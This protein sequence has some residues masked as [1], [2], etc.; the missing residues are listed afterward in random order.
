ME[1]SKLP[2]LY[3]TQVLGHLFPI[4]IAA[5]VSAFGVVAKFVFYKEASALKIALLVSLLMCLGLLVS[6]YY[7]WKELYIKSKFANSL[8]I[9]PGF[10]LPPRGNIGPPS[11]GLATLTCLMLSVENKG[12]TKIR[13]L[14]A[15]S[16][17]GAGVWLSSFTDSDFSTQ[18]GA[19]TELA[20]GQ[21][22]YI[23]IA[24]ADTSKNT[25]IELLDTAPSELRNVASA[26]IKLTEDVEREAYIKPNAERYL[27]FSRGSLGIRFLAEDGL[28]QTVWVRVGNQREPELAYPDSWVISR[29]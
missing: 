11:T 6:Q 10:Y 26:S 14:N 3:A 22:K 15:K 25:W 2:K 12:D 16:A 20:P 29:S 7:T 9:T 18:L 5:G 19:D 13:G 24:R 21:T 28:D 17:A 27:G 8:K 23:L 1:G 4:Y